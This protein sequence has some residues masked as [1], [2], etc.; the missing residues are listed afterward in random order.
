MGTTVYDGHQGLCLA[1]LWFYQDR[2]YRI[3]IWD[4]ENGDFE[5]AQSIL[6]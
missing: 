2:F 1:S 5:I 4:G 6:D 3:S